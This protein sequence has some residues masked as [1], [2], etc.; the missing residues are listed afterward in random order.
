MPNHE[1]KTHP[2]KIHIHV[3]AAMPETIVFAQV[4]AST[5]ESNV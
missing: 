5:A 4:R 1:F 2:F 3:W